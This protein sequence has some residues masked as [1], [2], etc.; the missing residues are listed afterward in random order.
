MHVHFV[1]VII[2][3]GEVPYPTMEETQY[4]IKHTDTK[5]QGARK[6]GVMFP[7]DTIVQAAIDS[8]AAIFHATQMDS[9]L[10]CESGTARNPQIR[11]SY[12]GTGASPP[13]QLKQRT[14]DTTPHL[15]GT[16]PV[17]PTDNKRALTCQIEGWPPGYVH[18]HTPFS[19]TQIFNHH[20]DAMD[21]KCKTHFIPDLLTNAEICTG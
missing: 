3:T 20:A 21:H 11:C 8:Y 17:P 15:P 10:H 19:W 6:R 1:M 7:P 9:S 12:K 16:P 4:L 18:I 2:A 14:P 5:V 13:D